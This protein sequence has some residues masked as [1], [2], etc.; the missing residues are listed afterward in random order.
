VIGATKWSTA[1]NAVKP[2]SSALAQNSCPKDGETHGPAWGIETPNLNESEGNE[3]STVHTD[4]LAGDKA[5]I[6]SNEASDRRSDVQLRIPYSA[7]RH[8]PG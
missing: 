8:P 2:S 7:Q 5:E 6:W 1:H 4:R 3:V